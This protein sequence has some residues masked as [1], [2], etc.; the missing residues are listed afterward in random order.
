M[1]KE[2]EKKAEEIIE[3]GKEKKEEIK[4]PEE[5]PEA[6]AAREAQEKLDEHR[7]RSDLGRKVKELN[8]KVDSELMSIS[9][10][11][12]QLLETRKAPETDEFEDER[13]LN[14]K[15]LDEYFNKKLQAEQSA[16]QKADADYNTGYF[17]TIGQFKN[18]EEEADYD[19]ICKELEDNHNIRRSNNAQADARMNWLEASNAYY[20]RKSGTKDNPLK[21]KGND[22]PL[23]AG[24]E[25]ALVIEKETPLPKLDSFAEEYIKATGMSE[26]SVKKAMAADLPLSLGKRY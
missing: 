20:K 13:I 19:A 17:K 4:E 7:E 14:K 3:E 25:G 1:P 9:G 5:T 24:S 21:G 16:R 22:L 2:I 8:E 18:T 11:I 15:E 23:G 10:K 26:E 12:D 6:K